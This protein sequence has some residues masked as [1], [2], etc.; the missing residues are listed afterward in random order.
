[1]IWVGSGLP[2]VDSGPHDAFGQL[3]HQEGDNVGASECKLASDWAV[4]MP[5]RG[6]SR[7]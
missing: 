7:T 4:A 1:M 5:A 3:D 2:S 6:V